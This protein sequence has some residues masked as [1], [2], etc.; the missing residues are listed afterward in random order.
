VDHYAAEQYRALICPDSQKLSKAEI[1]NP[2]CGCR[3]ETNT[4]S[5]K[6]QVCNHVTNQD[7]YTSTPIFRLNRGEGTGA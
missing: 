7:S 5:S 4:L 6:E 3:G 1:I 2:P